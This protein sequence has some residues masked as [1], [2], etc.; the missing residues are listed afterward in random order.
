MNFTMLNRTPTPRAQAEDN[1]ST[2]AQSAKWNA[3]MAYVDVMSDSEKHPNDLSSVF[4]WS[5]HRVE[6]FLNQL[7]IWIH[8][9][10]TFRK[11]PEVKGLLNLKYSLKD[12]PQVD[13]QKKFA[14]LVQELKSTYWNIYPW[15][16]NI[17]DSQIISEIRTQEKDSEYV[18]IDITVSW[19][20]PGDYIPDARP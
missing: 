16:K 4:T 5:S 6:Y 18:S 13:L 9:A 2:W 11:S 19:G 20:N 10:Q 1:M 14:T 15:F 8:E 12:N 17:P 7:R 3:H